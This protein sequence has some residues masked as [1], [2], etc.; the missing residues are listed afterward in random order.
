MRA[1]ME[2][3]RSESD[4]ERIRSRFLADF[5][6]DAR[7]DAAV[8][9][10]LRR[11]GSGRNRVVQV[12]AVGP[13]EA[14]RHLRSLEGTP[15]EL[16]V[17]DAP[18]LLDLPMRT[19]RLARFELQD[20]PSPF[21][22]R[23]WAPGSF[24][25]GL[26]MNVLERGVF[27]ANVSVFR[28]GDSA[29][30]SDQELRRLRPWTEVSE[31]LVRLADGAEQR[32]ATG[33]SGAFVLDLDGHL[34][35]VGADRA[36]TELPEALRREVVGFADSSEGE[37]N[38]VAGSALVR[39]VRLRGDDE[40][41]VLAFVEALAPFRV[42]ALLELPPAM[43]QVAALTARGLSND[44]IAV[45]LDRSPNTVRSHLKKLFDALGVKTRTELVRLVYEDGRP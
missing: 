33:L 29:P 35:M 24:R 12:S 26:S 27:L 37:R 31:A 1:I 3:L 4:P 9:L 15:L 43:R 36:P 32:R 34:R 21:R 38:T 25:S 11:D 10:G 18:S 16:V 20:I 23:V 30:F 7:A 28:R 6:Q 44:D 17:G 40:D 19:G 2:A 13:E 42:S 14:T 8:C 5:C 39:L 45:A 22:E 41:L